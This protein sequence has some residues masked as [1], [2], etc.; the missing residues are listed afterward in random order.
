MNFFNFDMEK[1]I[2]RKGSG[3]Y[4]AQIQIGP[5]GHN[6]STAAVA[7]EAG[8]VKFLVCLSKTQQSLLMAKWSNLYQGT[9]SKLS[10]TH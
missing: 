5:L 1:H 6:S 9:V 10:V 7:G 4:R 3:K 2:V 8:I